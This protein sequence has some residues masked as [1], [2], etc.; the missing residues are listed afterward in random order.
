M[1][2]NSFVLPSKKLMVSLSKDPDI[3]GEAYN[4][5][6]LL[7]N[8]STILLAIRIISN[9]WKQEQQTR[10][11]KEI[12]EQGAKL[13]DKFTGFV[14]DFKKI[15]NRLKQASESYESSLIK[16]SSGRG[17]LIVNAEKLKKMGIKPQKT[18]SYPRSLN[19]NEEEYK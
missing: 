19:N 7:V 5:N 18:I 3:F 1:R 6:I 16:L 14:D 11:V 10:N 8:P 17:N 2:S 12:A 9:L 15:G 4:Q 13:Y